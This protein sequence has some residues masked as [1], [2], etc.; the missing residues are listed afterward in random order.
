MGER[1]ERSKVCKCWAF[2]R[3]TFSPGIENPYLGALRVQQQSSPQSDRKTSSTR[4]PKGL[5]HQKLLAALAVFE[6][7]EG[8]RI[9]YVKGVE[10]PRRLLSSVRDN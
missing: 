7:I 6:V 2:R 5:V 3:C 4:I 1:H 10:R 8:S 9:I